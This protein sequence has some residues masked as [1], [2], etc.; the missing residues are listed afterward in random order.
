MV[1][2]GMVNTFTLAVVMTEARVLD[3]HSLHS[4]TGGPKIAGLSRITC[5]VFGAP[6][7][8]SS[9]LCLQGQITRITTVSFSNTSPLGPSA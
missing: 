9:L 3:S 2:Y 7:V 4:Q 8:E 5:A 1:V 6:N